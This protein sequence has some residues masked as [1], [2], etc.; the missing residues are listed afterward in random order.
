MMSSSVILYSGDISYFIR[1]TVGTCFHSD[2]VCRFVDCRM[3]Q[4]VML[5][6]GTS[7]SSAYP[8]MKLIGTFPWG[9]PSPWFWLL[10]EK[11]AVGIVF[12]LYAVLLVINGSDKSSHNAFHFFANRTT[13]KSLKNST[14]HATK[15]VLFRLCTILVF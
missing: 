14:L 2:N 5:T 10:M 4:S 6:S 1:R 9:C 7:F 11:W 8:R 15:P 3:F 12:C 13:H